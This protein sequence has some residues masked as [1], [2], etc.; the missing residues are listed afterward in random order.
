MYEDMDAPQERESK[1]VE[2]VGRINNGV[3][4]VQLT[5]GDHGDWAGFYLDVEISSG[6]VVRCSIN[7]GTAAR[8]LMAQTK[9]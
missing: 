7:N 9:P 5:K 8:L 6:E 4:L 1:Y 3:C 2:R